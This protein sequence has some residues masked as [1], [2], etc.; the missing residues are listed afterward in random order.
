MYETK[1][2]VSTAW[3]C[4]LTTARL[5]PRWRYL[6]T[7]HP[8]RHKGLILVLPEKGQELRAHLLAIGKSHATRGG[9]VKIIEEGREGEGYAQ[10]R[11]V[12]L[13]GR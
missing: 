3:F 12:H 7:S 11:K 2:P 4:V 10:P 6:K 8:L 9:C 5:Y 1:R 13:E